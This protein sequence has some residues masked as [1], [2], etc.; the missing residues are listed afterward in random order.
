MLVALDDPSQTR[1]TIAQRVGSD[2]TT[3]EGL[4][5]IYVKDNLYAISDKVLLVGRVNKVMEAARAA[6]AARGIL[7][8]NNA[9]I[10]DNKEVKALLHNDDAA[11]NAWMQLKGLKTLFNKSSVYRELKQKMPL[12][13]IFTESD[14]DAVVCNVMLNDDD[15]EMKTTIKA[16]ENSEYAQLLNTTLSKPSSDVL[17]AIPNSMDYIVTMSVKGDNFVKL[18]QIQQ[19][20]GLFGKLPYIGRIDLASILATVDGP[21]TVGIARDPHLEGEWNAVLATRS[22]NPDG[23]LK[24]IST[25]ANSMGQAPE[26]YDGE[27]VYQY[28]NKMIRIG[29]VDEILYVKMLD[30]EQTEGYAYEMPQARTVFDNALLGVFAQT[31]ASDTARAYFDFSLSSIYDGTGHF[32]TN[33]TGVNVTQEL[34][35]ALCTFKRPSPYD[36]NEDDESS[37]DVSSLVGGA[38][39]KLQP[40]N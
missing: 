25:F 5:C 18:Q 8:H 15:V 7:A 28:D 26:M 16:A 40:L 22:T 12:I 13:E 24:Q 27:Y 33:Q 1:K 19:L 32:T 4:D 29:I 38:I 23:V 30:Y 9:S 14:I 37:D 34:L 11:I 36:N 35:R 3:I 31:A 21:F 20:L 2:F 6:K 17:K 39:D 10:I